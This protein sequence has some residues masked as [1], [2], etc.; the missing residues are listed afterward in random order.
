MTNDHDREGL[1]RRGLRIVNR[2]ARRRWRHYHKRIDLDELRGIGR[3]TLVWVLDHF[4]P[5]RGDFDSYA[6]RRIGGAMADEFRKRCRRRVRRRPAMAASLASDRLARPVR[7]IRRGM[8][9]RRRNESMLT[10]AR[11]EWGAVLSCHDVDEL[12]MCSLPD[13]ESSTMATSLAERVR[14]VVQELPKPEREIIERHYFAGEPLQVVAEDLGL[15]RYAVSRLHRKSLSRVG[16][17]V[18]P[19]VEAD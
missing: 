11:D 7:H 8:R 14:G 12:A 17:R 2:L 4:D 6:R 13:P 3:E 1:A 19:L 10:R 18:E 9:D 5:R 16:R 15:S